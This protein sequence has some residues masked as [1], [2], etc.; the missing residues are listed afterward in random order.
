MNP[1]IKVTWQDVPENFTAEKIRRVKTYFEQKYNSKNV[2]II[3][4]TL[5]N[6]Q[7]TRLESLEVTDSILDNQYQKNLMK[8]FIKDNSIDVKWELVDRLDNRVNGEID[9]LNQNTNRRNFKICVDGGVNQSNIKYL[10]VESVV[11]GSYILKSQNPIKNIMILKTSN[12][13]EK[14]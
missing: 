14:Y 6:V 5:S 9:K 7:N 13:Y 3:T 2:K 4:K 10:N 11:S 1:F 8:D 12:E